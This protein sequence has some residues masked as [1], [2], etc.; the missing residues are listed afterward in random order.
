MQCSGQIVGVVSVTLDHMSVLGELF[1]TSS[2]VDECWCM[3]PVRNPGAHRPDRSKNRRDM[4]RR[5]VARDSPGLLALAG[6]CAVGWC[7]LGPRHGYPQYRKAADEASWAIP[8]IYV[9]PG[10]DREEVGRALIEEAVCVA[11][12]GGASVI[13]GPPPAWLPGD[14]AAVAVA[15]QLF[16]ENGFVR[17]GPGKRMPE[18]RRKLA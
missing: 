3:W 11:A 2:G 1:G 16:L 6:Q 5:L 15:T 7:A 4:E 14:A 9:R 10:A 8:C 18:L 13:E 17:V 12:T